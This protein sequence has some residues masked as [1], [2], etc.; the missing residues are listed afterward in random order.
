MIYE[1]TIPFLFFWWIRLATRKNDKR[2]TQ[3]VHPPE[4]FTRMVGLS[5][6]HAHAFFNFHGGEW[7]A[8]SSVTDRAAIVTRYCS[9]IDIYI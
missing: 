8:Q 5:Q 3:I 4:S 9:E 7:D 2:T 1:I 6:K